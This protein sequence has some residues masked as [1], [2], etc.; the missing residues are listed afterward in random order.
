MPGNIDPYSSPNNGLTGTYFSNSLRT[1][2]TRRNPLCDARVRAE[3]GPLADFV[4]LL[5]FLAAILSYPCHLRI[6]HSTDG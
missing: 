2:V 3:D 1:S 5:R 6:H 4:W